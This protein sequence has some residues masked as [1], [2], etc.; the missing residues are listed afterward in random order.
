[1]KIVYV[2]ILQD[3]RFIKELADIVKDN[4]ECELHIGG[5]GKFENYFQYM[6]SK[7]ENIKYYGKL[8]YQKKH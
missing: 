2:G 7:Y 1:M 4:N 6:A 3:K 5:F 8:P